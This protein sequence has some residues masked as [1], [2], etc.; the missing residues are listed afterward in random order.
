[1]RRNAPQIGLLPRA[2]ADQKAEFRDVTQGEY[3]A[4]ADSGKQ[5][6][7]EAGGLDFG[8]LQ[9]ATQIRGNPT[10]ELAG[11]GV[12]RSFDRPVRDARGATSRARGLSGSGASG[13]GHRTGGGLGLGFHTGNT[14][15]WCIVCF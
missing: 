2:F 14:S 8:G 13:F 5:T 1:M 3:S 12:G 4:A 9:G 7:D 6:V 15:G 11:R 10:G